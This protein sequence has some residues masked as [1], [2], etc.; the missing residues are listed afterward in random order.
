MKKVIVPQV[1]IDRLEKAREALY[2]LFKDSQNLYKLSYGITDIM[3][4]I[5]HKKYPE[6]K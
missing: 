1:D 2:K 4:E 6:V 3:Y 5:T